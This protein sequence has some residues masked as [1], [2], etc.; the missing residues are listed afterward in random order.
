MDNLRKIDSIATK[1]ALAFL[2]FALLAS[3]FASFVCFQSQYCRVAASYRG[4]CCWLLAHHAA[5][6]TETS[7]YAEFVQQAHSVFDSHAYAVGHNVGARAVVLE[8]LFI[9]NPAIGGVGKLEVNIHF[10]VRGLD[11][12]HIAFHR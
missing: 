11:V 4:A 6:A 10:L 5:I 7:L 8:L 3:F 9:G 12:G 1:S 2:F